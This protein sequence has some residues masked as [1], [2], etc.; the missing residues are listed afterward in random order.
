MSNGNVT[1]IVERL[2][3]DGYVVREKVPG[4]RRAS[5]V[6][7]TSKGRAEF[8][9]QAAAHEVWSN[10][11]FADVSSAEAVQISESLDGVVR[12]LDSKDKSDDQ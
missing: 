9:R 12:H 6:K 4:D 1:G 2:V 7:M 5:L 3:D 11:M 10:A 8:A